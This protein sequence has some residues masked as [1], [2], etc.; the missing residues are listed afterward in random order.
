[1]GSSSFSSGRHLNPV[2]GD[3]ADVSGPHRIRLN[4]H[5]HERFDSLRCCRMNSEQSDAGLLQRDPALNC[6]LPEVLIE[7][8]HDARFGF[9]QVQKNNVFPSGIISAGPEDVVAPSAKCL[10]AWLWKVLVSKEA[11]LCLNRLGLE[12]VKLESDR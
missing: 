3:D 1:M 2:G 10:D 8:Q 12:S 7:R 6:N 9:G 4:K 5:P 11:H